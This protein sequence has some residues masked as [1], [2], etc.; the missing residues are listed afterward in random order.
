SEK[1]LREASWKERK[2]KMYNNTNFIINPLRLSIRNLA[3]HTTKQSLKH[4]IDEALKEANVKASTRHS[5]KVT[6]LVDEE[7]RVPIPGGE[8]GAT[9]KRCKGFAFAD[10]RN[11]QVAL[12]CLRMMNNNNKYLDSDRR[13]IVEFAIEDK[14]ALKQLEHSKKKQI[15]KKKEMEVQKDIEKSHKGG[16]GAR[17]RAARRKR[18]EEMV[19]ADEGSDAAADKAEAP[20]VA[21]EANEAATGSGSPRKK[22][23]PA[24]RR[25]A[26][27]K[28]QKEEKRK[29]KAPSSDL[30]DDRHELERL[31]QAVAKSRQEKPDDTEFPSRVRRRSGKKREADKLLET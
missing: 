22:L 8:E 27:R 1:R 26:R 11:N 24:A 31:A 20:K 6:V 29:A 25:R 14:R 5:V 16:R 13:A 10:F 30:A 28:E 2:Y 15:E 23:G 12:K 18:A 21:T 4:A 9:T 17:Q 3:V 7:R 19:A